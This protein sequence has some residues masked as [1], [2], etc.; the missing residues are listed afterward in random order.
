DLGPSDVT[1]GEGGAAKR[2]GDWVADDIAVLEGWRSRHVHGDDRVAGAYD[3]PVGGADKQFH[4]PG[5]QGSRR[6]L[7]SPRADRHSEARLHGGLFL[8]CYPRRYPD[9][10]F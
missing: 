5:I 2:G 8:F 9:A 7:T 4:R 10:D 1:E 3:Q 6:A